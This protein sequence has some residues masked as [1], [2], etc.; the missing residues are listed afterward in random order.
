MAQMKQE[1]QSVLRCSERFEKD[2][3]QAFSEY[4]SRYD[5]VLIVYLSETWRRVASMF[6]IVL[7][8]RKGIK[9]KIE[10]QLVEHYMESK[11][12]SKNR[13][14]LF[15]DWD[16]EYAYYPELV[17]K[18]R[19]VQDHMLVMTLQEEQ[20]ARNM[21]MSEVD[22]FS[23]YQ[24]NVWSCIG[25]VESK[26]DLMDTYY[27]PAVCMQLCA[28]VLV[29]EQLLEYVTPKQFR[30]LEMKNMALSLREIPSITV[31]YEEN[32]LPVVLELQYRFSA[33]P[34]VKVE[35][36]HVNRTFWKEKKYREIDRQSVCIYIARDR[37]EEMK[38]PIIYRKQ[39]L[40]DITEMNFWNFMNTIEGPFLYMKLGGKSDTKSNMIGSMYSY[41]IFYKVLKYYANPFSK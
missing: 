11:N 15:F 28:S 20:N 41:F 14:L 1:L 7:Q 9:Q 8:E 37:K 38:L 32:T 39:D 34:K 19:T 16:M 25:E 21:L 3:L 36:V 23:L 33:L 12:V 6:K 26:K 35:K 10:I 18:I 29:G 4:V 2:K 24:E 31:L 30:A 13:L 5:R 27:V 40:L 17:E 22:V